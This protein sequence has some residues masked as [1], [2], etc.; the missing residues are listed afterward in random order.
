VISDAGQT[1][2][3]ETGSIWQYPRLQTR[4]AQGMRE[5]T[6]KGYAKKREDTRGKSAV[7]S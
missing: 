5:D 2:K 7:E 3:K 4:D 6:R 1:P